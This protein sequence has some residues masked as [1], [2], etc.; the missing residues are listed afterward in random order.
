MYIN[1]PVIYCTVIPPIICHPCGSLVILENNILLSIISLCLQ[2][3]NHRYIESNILTNS[4]KFI[5]SRFFSFIFFLLGQQWS[6]PYPIYI[7]PPVWMS[8]FGYTS[9]DASTNV[10]KSVR[11]KFPIIISLSTVWFIYYMHIISFFQSSTLIFATLVVNNTTY[12]YI[13][14]LVLLLMYINLAVHK[15]NKSVFASSNNSSSS[16]ISYKLW[17][18]AK[19]P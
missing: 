15:W 11:L 2:K 17:H 18:M 7:T 5:L 14:G 16:F 1:M 9:Y 10:K 19:S 4:Y 6:I 12:G 13:S 8:M 3:H